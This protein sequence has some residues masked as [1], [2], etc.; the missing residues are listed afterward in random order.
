[1]S[2]TTDLQ[3]SHKELNIKL[4]E[5]LANAF[6]EA[7]RVMALLANA[8]ALHSLYLKYSPF[9]E[10]LT[11]TS[12][13]EIVTDGEAFAQSSVPSFL[14][15]LD[16]QLKA[17]ILLSEKTKIMT[18]SNDEGV[19]EYTKQF[20]NA[21][22]ENLKENWEKGIYMAIQFRDDVREWY[23]STMAWLEEK[24]KEI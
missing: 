18:S 5:N 22:K 19:W 23:N 16:A 8:V 4:Q 6:S 20:I 7:E 17:D 11:A 14:K 15:V 2:V 21:C 3:A 13:W 24:I 9:E 1:M 10:E 12:T